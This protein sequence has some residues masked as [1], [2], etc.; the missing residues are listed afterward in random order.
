MSGRSRFASLG[1]S[2]Q[3]AGSLSQHQRNS[4]VTILVARSCSRSSRTS[5]RNFSVFGARYATSPETLGMKN[6]HL[7]DP[8]VRP[9]G[10][11]AVSANHLVGIG[12]RHDNFVKLDE[13][14]WLNGIEPHAR[15]GKSI[16]LW[17]LR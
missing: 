6:A 17:Y 11:L 8:D 13:F 16:W 9:T 2:Q 7:I 3:R 1:W 14:R 4:I 5:I 10:W 12:M 15:I